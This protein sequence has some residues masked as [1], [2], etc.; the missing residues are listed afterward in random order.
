MALCFPDYEKIKNLRVSPEPGELYLINF[1]LEKLDNSYEI[2]FQPFLNGDRPD[3]VILRRNTGALIIEIKDWNLKHYLN[4]QGKN[5]PWK[6]LKNKVTIKS[7]IAQVEKYKDNL[8]NL[9]IDRLFERYVD[10]YRSYGL[11]KTAVYFHNENTEK[12]KNF[13]FE[14][15]YTKVI[16]KDALN[17]IDFDRFLREINFHRYSQ[18][19]D[20]DLYFSFQRFLKPPIHN[21]DEGKN[22]VYTKEQQRL[23]QS[24]ANRRQ[25]IRGVA[26]CGKTKTLAGRAV[27]AYIRTQDRV[28][29]LTF[30]LALRNYIHD[31]ISEV[32]EYFPWSNFYIIN[33]HQFFNIEANNHN[34]KIENID[35]DYDREDFFDSVKE[36]INPYSTILI[37]EVQDYKTEW[38]RLIVNYFLAPQGE[39]VV[40]GDEKQNIY[41][42]EMGRDRFPVIPTIPGAWN[43]LKTSFRMNSAILNIAQKFQNHYFKAIY[44]L[45]EEVNIMQGDIFTASSES[46]L[47]YYDKPTASYEKIFGLIERET[48]QIGIHPNDITILALEHEVISNLEYYFRSIARER[49]TYTCETI[50]EFKNIDSSSK[51][52]EIKKADLEKIRKGR[53]IHFWG[54]SGTTKLSTIHSYKGWEAHTLILI[55]SEINNQNNHNELIYTALTRASKNLIIIDIDSNGLYRD[56]F[57]KTINKSYQTN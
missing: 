46:I 19:F 43:Q 30:N 41:S 57:E 52:Q 26:G 37:D 49:T 15:G 54:N 33:Y 28:L 23:I 29:I 40:F 17:F 12:V 27:S 2:Y 50:E 44:E 13:C 1:L 31:R 14:S 35:K 25:K 22:I 36:R 20:D 38:L 6:L 4:P 5:K 18:F 32:R 53:K 21:P 3:I 8:Y 39:L 7:P 47:K 56:F 34:L 16:G 55:I 51:S 48:K 10:N 24:Q 42:R 11:V 9:H 45:D